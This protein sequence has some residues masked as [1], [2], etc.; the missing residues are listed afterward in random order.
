LVRSPLS[1]KRSI[2]LASLAWF[3]DL[4]IMFES[5]SN[6]P[7]LWITYF[8]SL[9]KQLERILSSC[10]FKFFASLYILIKFCVSSACKLWQK[11]LLPRY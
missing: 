5:R 6:S 2:M 7:K 11:V 4:S 3:L 8:S 1:M 9:F 10:M